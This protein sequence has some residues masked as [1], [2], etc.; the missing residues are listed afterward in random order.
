MLSITAPF[1]PQEKLEVELLVNP[2]NRCE[3]DNGISPLDISGNIS[4]SLWVN[5]SNLNLGPDIFTKGNYTNGYALWVDGSGRLRF[6]VNY[7]SMVSPPNQLSNGTW[8]YVTITRAS[9]DDTLNDIKIYTN[10]ALVA[11]NTNNQSFEIDNE[12]FFLVHPTSGLFGINGR[13]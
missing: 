3:E 13:I 8:T 12:D 7:T 1:Y 10:G 9:N 11:A 2:S 4:I 6:H 5:I